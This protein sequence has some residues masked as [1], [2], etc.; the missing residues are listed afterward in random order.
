MDGWTDGLIYGLTDRRTDR[1]LYR[2]ARM[3]LKT[4][5]KMIE[6]TYN[7]FAEICDI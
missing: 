1:P 3:H 2:D 7:R 6:M 5:G 4:E